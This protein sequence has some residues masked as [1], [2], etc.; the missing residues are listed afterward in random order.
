MKNKLYCALIASI[1]SI[2]LITGLC[3]CNATS[4]TSISDSQNQ[5][6]INQNNNDD[7]EDATNSVNIDNLGELTEKDQLT[8]YDSNDVTTITYSDSGI[9][10]TNNSVSIS[11]N[12]ATITKKGDYII[13]GTTNDGQLII[14]SDKEKDVHLILDNASITSKTNAPIYIKSADKVIIT[15]KDGTSNYLSDSKD[16]SRQLFLGG[17]V[18]GG[19]LLEKKVPFPS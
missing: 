1:T 13:T 16:F 4:S 10:S 6:N 9:K 2:F 18:E 7:G 12:T 11:G 15:L 5:T 17:R 3:G 14:D 19:N 8:D